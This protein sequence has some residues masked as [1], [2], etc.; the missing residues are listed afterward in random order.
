M[1]P[2]ILAIVTANAIVIVPIFPTDAD[3]CEHPRGR[4]H[5]IAVLDYAA[6]KLDFGYCVLPP[7]SLHT[8]AC[9]DIPLPP[10]SVGP[11]PPPQHIG[12][13]V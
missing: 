9:R 10:P 8:V 4:H 5:R 3:L 2:V 6:L 12:H 7:P 11:A 13:I 1:A